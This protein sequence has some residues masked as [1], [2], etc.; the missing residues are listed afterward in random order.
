MSAMQTLTERDITRLT[1]KAQLCPVIGREGNLQ[2]SK[3]LEHVTVRRNALEA[4][5]LCCQQSTA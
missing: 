5:I 3:K 2:N 1:P 4:S